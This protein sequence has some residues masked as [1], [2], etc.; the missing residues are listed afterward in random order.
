MLEHV[1]VDIETMGTTPGSIILSIGAVRFDPYGTT[2]DRPFYVNIL[3]RTQG[4]FGFET[5]QETVEWWLKP[6]NAEARARLEKDPSP[7]N[8][9]AALKKFAEYFKESGASFVWGHGCSFDVVLIEQAF[10]MVLSE[11]DIPWNFRAHRDTRT[12]FSLLPQDWEKPN[13]G[14]ALLPHFALHDAMYQA[15]CVQAA[16]RALHLKEFP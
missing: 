3:G 16:I 13:M 11:H 9:D 1:M 12:L 6:E 8:I 4:V 2:I 14:T 10:R 15:E 5:S 7:I